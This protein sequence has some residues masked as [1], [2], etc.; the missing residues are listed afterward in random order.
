MISKGGNKP[1]PDLGAE[2][3]S[4]T[5][6]VAGIGVQHFDDPRAVS[7]VVEVCLMDFELH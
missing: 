1:L 3:L 2:R 4:T 5:D 6:W 7:G